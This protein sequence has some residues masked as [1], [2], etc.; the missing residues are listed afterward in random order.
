MTELDNM[1][2]KFEDVKF[3]NKNGTLFLTK[4]FLSWK[5]EDEKTI[6]SNSY[7]SIITLKISSNRNSKTLLKVIFFDNVFKVFHFSSLISSQKQI[8]DRNKC[9]D[10]LLMFLFKCKQKNL[11][12]KKRILI[13]NPNI[14]KL[15]K[16]LV[17]GGIEYPHIFWKKYINF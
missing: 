5:N 15:Y 2:F 13:K 9:K 12:Q 1:L 4:K 14:Y 8:E 7:E 16:D 17:V 6:I 3:K 11:E 10:F